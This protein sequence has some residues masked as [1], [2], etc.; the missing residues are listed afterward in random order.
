MEGPFIDHHVDPI[1]LW[2]KLHD[3][4][5]IAR[6]R[7]IRA[8]QRRLDLREMQATAKTLQFLIG[9]LRAPNLTDR[10]R[11]DVLER[12]DR[13]ARQLLTHVERRAAA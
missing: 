2:K 13:V 10:K 8:D 5:D 1:T 12:L 6:E 9:E 3:P 11:T 7:A 4:D